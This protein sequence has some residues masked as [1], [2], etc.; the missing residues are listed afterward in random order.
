METNIT[1]APKQITKQTTNMLTV[2]HA[3][4]FDISQPDQKAEW[5]TLRGKLR[6]M[7]LKCFGTWGRD[8]HFLTWVSPEGSPVELETSCL[9][10]DQWNTAPVEGVSDKGLRVFDW[11]MDYQPNRNP[12]IK[13]GH[14]LEQTQAMKAARHNTVKCGYCGHM[15]PYSETQTLCHACADSEYLTEKDFPLLRLRRIDAPD[16]NKYPPLTDTETA[17]LVSVIEPARAAA[18][19]ARLAKTR[20][21]LIADTDK[22]I[23]DAKTERD[24]KLWLLDHAEAIA[25]VIFYN[26]TQRFCFGWRNPLTPAEHSHLRDVLCE[27]PFDYDLETAQPSPVF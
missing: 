6:G 5:E 15:Q 18:K 3:Y 19:A 24:G 14:W 10:D 27:F 12:N 2:I 26:H 9:F 11:A 17:E 16:A 21:D 4:N 8:S 20:A 7:G 1:D 25:N 23:A 13:R 22:E